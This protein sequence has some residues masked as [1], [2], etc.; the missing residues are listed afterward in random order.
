MVIGTRWHQD[1]LYSKILEE[2]KTD[3][4]GGGTGWDSFIRTAYTTDEKT[5]VIF[6]EKFS[7][8][9]LEQLRRTKGPYEFAAQYLNNP[10]DESAAPFKK[11]WIKRYL[12]GTP[13]PAS[14]YLTVDPGLSVQRDADY[15]GLVVA[16]Q[17]SSRVIRVVDY[18]RKRLA[19]R[20]L[21]QEIFLL[22]E[23]WNLHRVGIETFAF[24]KTLKYDVQAEQ[25]RRNQYF[26]IDELGSRRGGREPPVTKEA[27]ISRLQ[28]FFEQGLIELRGDMQALEDEILSFPRGKYDDLLD[29]LSY[30]LDY[31]VPSVDRIAV[32]GIIPGSYR[33]VLQKTWAHQGGDLYAKFMSDLKEHPET[34]YVP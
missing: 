28:P 31:L 10:I 27:R 8:A 1:D 9:H 15:S 33:D 21:V 3:A 32:P 7:L 5:D 20:D 29:A 22:V 25:R 6:P 23:K 12:P 11:S 14:L 2:T 34:P 30:Q 17:F 4:S 19:P 24:Q 13:H 16:G 18:V 26:S